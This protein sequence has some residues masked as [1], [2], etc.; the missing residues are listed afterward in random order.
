MLNIIYIIILQVCC[1]TLKP[2]LYY[3]FSTKIYLNIC[4]C[5]SKFM[6]FSLLHKIPFLGCNMRYLTH[7]ILLNTV[8]VYFTCQRDG[9]LEYSDVWANVILGVSGRVFLDDIKYS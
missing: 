7:F 2:T 1:Y 8:M 4:L 9:V 6:S 3:A 5:D